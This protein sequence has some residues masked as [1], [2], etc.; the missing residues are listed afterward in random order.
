MVDENSVCTLQ[1]ARLE[2]KKWNGVFMGIVAVCCGNGRK[3][4]SEAL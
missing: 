2:S 4:L 3:L 1:S